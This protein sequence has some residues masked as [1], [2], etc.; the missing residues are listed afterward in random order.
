V[1]L[2]PAIDLKEGRCVRLKQGK[3]DKSTVFSEDPVAMAE[4]WKSLGCR[5]LHVVDL[6]GAFA[7]EPQHQELIQRIVEVM[8]EVPVQVGGGIR[9]RD[10][11]EGYL[12]E[13][14]SAIVLGTRAVEDP[15]FLVEMA[16]TFPAEIILGLDAK[17]GKVATHGWANTERVTALDFAH[18]LKGLPLAG[19]VYTDIER[20]GMLTGLN[21]EST[22]E[23]SKRS[24]I[25]T[26]ASGGVRELSDLK[27]LKIVFE[28]DVGLFFG[29]ITGRAIYEGTLDFR[30]G[31][32]LLDS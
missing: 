30:E 17:Q 12:S 24:G 11:I 8:G 15:G 31:Q 6:D 4:H 23:I 13:G 1:I 3:M 14:V 16:E 5:R 10:N 29:A 18:S 22:W 2:V 27:A 19:M 26:I 32:A 21:I 25:P 7:G 28:N 20:D 9:T